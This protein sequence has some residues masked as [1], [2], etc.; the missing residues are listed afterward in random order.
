MYNKLGQGEYIFANVQ[1]RPETRVLDLRFN[2]P[3]LFDLPLGIDIKGGIF[4]NEKFRETR[5]DIGII[6]QFDGA[7]SIKTAWSNKTSRLI[8]IDTTSI[9]STRKL[10]KQLDISYNGGGIE[11]F[12]RNLD[13]RFNPSKGWEIR[14]NGSVGLKRVIRNNRIEALSRPDLDFNI[15]YDTLKLN[16]LQTE[17]KLSSAFY[18]PAFNI[19]TFKIGIEGGLQYNEAKIFENELY[20]I[21]GNS[22]LRGFDELSVLT[23]AYIVTTAEFRLLL[24]RNSYLSFPFIDYGLTRITVEDGEQWDTAISIGM[25]INF[26]TPAGIFNVSFA[27]GKRLGNPI[28]FGNTK[29]HFGYVSLF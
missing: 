10:P 8:E 23:S 26:S 7:S 5:G 3:Y 14:L 11:Y 29:I 13:Y 21:G 22:L 20:R 1:S 9:L 17:V 2:Y 28:D 24:D 6:Y 15:A 27:A 25:G 19:S 16:T 18:I 12:Y 4:F